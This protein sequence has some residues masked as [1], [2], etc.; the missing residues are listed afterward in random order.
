MSYIFCLLLDIAVL[1]CIAWLGWLVWR[2]A[3][4][5][6]VLVMLVLLLALVLPGE[7]LFTCPKCGNT[8]KVQ[9]Y[10]GTLDTPLCIQ[11]K[12]NSSED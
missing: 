10:K 11:K 4:S 12:Q 3:T 2:G 1:M 5:W 9:V 8:V 6:I 7:D